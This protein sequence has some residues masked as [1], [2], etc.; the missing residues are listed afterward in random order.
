MRNRSPEHSAKIGI[1]T[2]SDRASQGI[3]EDVSGK[4]IIDVLNECLITSW[5]AVYRVVPDNRA[6]IERTLMQLADDEACCLIITTGG[7]GPAPRDVTPE[8]TCAVCEKILPGFGE[9]MRR[10][11]LHSVPTAMLSRQTA[12]IRGKTLIVNLPGKPQAVRECLCAVLPAIPSCLTLIGA[13]HIE[14]Q[15]EMRTFRSPL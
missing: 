14:L 10:V 4:V 13:A 3:Y 12:G 8:A 15:E 9:Q 6:S 1:L 7:T 11:S 5:T 2:C